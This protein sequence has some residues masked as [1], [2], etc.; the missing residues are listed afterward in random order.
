MQCE[1]FGD[2]MND[3]ITPAQAEIC[4][5][6][7]V[8]P[9]A[10]PGALKVGISENV[11]GGQVMPINGLRHDPAGDTTGWYIW[12]GEDLSQDPDFF[13]PL[14][15]KHLA[16][17]CPQAI[18]YLALP[19]GWRFLLAPGYEDVWFDKELELTSGIR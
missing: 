9:L 1:Q 15:V 3:M 13:Q 5:R 17:W 11:C 19:V 2:S 4:R 12:A 14:H 8:P 10:A 7:D 6:F 18:P 16:E